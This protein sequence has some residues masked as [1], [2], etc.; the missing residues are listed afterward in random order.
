MTDYNGTR[1]SHN[2]RTFTIDYEELPHGVIEVDT[3]G[4]SREG[5]A[6]YFFGSGA[7][8]PSITST[9][10]CGQK[11]LSGHQDWEHR[12]WSNLWHTFA[13]IAWAKNNG[14]FGSLCYTS[15]CVNHDHIRDDDR[16]CE[17]DECDY[18]WDYE[19]SD[20][21]DFG[22][23]S[24]MRH[25]MEEQCEG[26]MLKGIIERSGFGEVDVSEPWYNPNSMNWVR[27]F[28]WRVDAR[29]MDLYAHKVKYYDEWSRPQLK[30]A[31]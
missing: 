27:T 4:W 12:F 6:K 26:M 25:Y 24:E 29:A 30:E 1:L 5:L 14:D 3:E 22:C 15:I 11:L 2:R 10:C 23:W 21:M 19:A 20:N 17:C 18:C 31:S 9:L 13:W 28:T 16:D 8:A 7:A